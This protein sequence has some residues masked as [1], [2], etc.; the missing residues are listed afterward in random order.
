MSGVICII[1]ILIYCP[2]S[3]KEI[4]THREARS[5]A[6]L[7]CGVSAWQC[8]ASTQEGPDYLVF[9]NGTNECY[10]MFTLP[11]LGNFSNT[12]VMMLL[13]VK[14]LKSASTSAV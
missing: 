11:M 9:D 3:K 14:L 4:V 12:H 1:L 2:L 5:V 10:R 8:L 13:W 6:C 7:R